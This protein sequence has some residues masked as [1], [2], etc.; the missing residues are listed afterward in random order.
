MSETTNTSGEQKPPQ[1]KMMMAI[2]CWFLGSLGIHRYMMGYSNWWVQL[3]LTFLCG[4][5]YIW[6]LYDLI[7]ILMG[8]MKMADGRDLE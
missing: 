2:V 5:G 3:L 4:I 8:K 1:K 7:M 6:A